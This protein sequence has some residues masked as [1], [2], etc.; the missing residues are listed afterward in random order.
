MITKYVSPFK[1]MED[2]KT[3][4]EIATKKKRDGYIYMFVNNWA[5]NPNWNLHN[6]VYKLESLKDIDTIQKIENYVLKYKDSNTMVN[7]L[8]NILFLSQW[9]TI[10]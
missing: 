8:L 4:F 5:M 2:D 6:E 7:H 10:Q 3:I 1:P 9:K